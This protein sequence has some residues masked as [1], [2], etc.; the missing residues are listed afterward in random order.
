MRALGAQG[1]AAMQQKAE[2]QAAALEQAGEAT[3]ERLCFFPMW[4]E[5]EEELKSDIA[6]IK[7]CGSGTA[8]MI[9]AAKFITHFAKEMPLIHLDIAG[10]ASVKKPLK[11]YGTSATGIGVRLLTEYLRNA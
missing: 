10:V 3:H 8:G 1:I 2:A 4:K 9:T 5:Y 7:N 11:P 6:D